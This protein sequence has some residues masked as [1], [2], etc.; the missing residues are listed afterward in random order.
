MQPHIKKCPLT[1]NTKVS[2]KD[3]EY[4]PRM[5]EEEEEEEEDEED[6]L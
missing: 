1:Q 5:K 6:C 2:E 3:A 4:S